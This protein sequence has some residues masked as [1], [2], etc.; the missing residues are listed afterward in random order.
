MVGTRARSRPWL[1]PAASYGSCGRRPFLSCPPSAQKNLTP[2][3]PDRVFSVTGFREALL[4]TPQPDSQKLKATEGERNNSSPRMKQSHQ[5]KA[6]RS[7]S[8][9]LYHDDCSHQNIT[10]LQPFLSISMDGVSWLPCIITSLSWANLT[11]SL[12]SWGQTSGHL[13]F[14][15]VATQTSL[16]CTTEALMLFAVFS[17]SLLV[18]SPKA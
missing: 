14:L 3:W 13:S 12:A 17:R 9:A 5:G 8:H 7:A 11:A 2:A 18:F 1:C 10:W 16:H 4:F 15:Q 6:G